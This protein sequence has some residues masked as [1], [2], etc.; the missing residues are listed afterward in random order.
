[1]NLLIPPK[2]RDGAEIIIGSHQCQRRVQKRKVTVEYITQRPLPSPKTDNRKRRKKNVNFQ[3][4]NHTTPLL[5]VYGNA[6]SYYRT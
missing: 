3:S 4:G 2:E 1:M 6:T 5:I